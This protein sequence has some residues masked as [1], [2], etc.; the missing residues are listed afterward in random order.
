MRRLFSVVNKIIKT[1]ELGDN[2]ST[3]N[4]TRLLE[5]ISTIHDNQK[6]P[7]GLFIVFGWKNEWNKKYAAICDSS[8]DIFSKSKVNIFNEGSLKKI[9]ETVNFDG[10]ILVDRDGHILRSGA[11]LEGLRPS[12]LAD[13]LSLRT[14]NKDLSSRLGFVQKV[15]TRH[16]TA[17]SASYE[18]R[19][20]TTYTVSEETGDVHMFER[21]KIIFSTIEGEMRRK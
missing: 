1:L 2:V 21:G 15:H 20:T 6:K 11:I 3:S 18:L 9:S 17:I 5:V 14:Q 13:F 7:F 4:K 16:L 12:R 8:Q 10:A 19:G